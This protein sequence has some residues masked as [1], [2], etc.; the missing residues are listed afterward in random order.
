VWFADRLWLTWKSAEI[1]LELCGVHACVVVSAPD[2]FGWQGGG[3]ASAQVPAGVQLNPW[4]REITKTNPEDWR[5][6]RGDR[7][8]P[9]PYA[10]AAEMPN[11]DSSKISADFQVS[12]TGPALDAHFVDAGE[13]RRC[14]A[15]IERYGTLVAPT[16]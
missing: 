11:C 5:E 12:H 14:D 7:P 13:V 4:S 10:C 16:T 6:S 9:R 2:R 8:V 3:Y 1:L 15:L